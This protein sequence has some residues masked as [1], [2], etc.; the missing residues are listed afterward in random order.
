ML[1]FCSYIFSS[2]IINMD[3][4]KAILQGIPDE[5]PIVQ[6]YDTEV[7]HAPKRKDILTHDE[8]K[9]ALESGLATRCLGNI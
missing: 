4:K 3:F 8:K 5:L 9:L 7:S 6:A 1:Y 2:K